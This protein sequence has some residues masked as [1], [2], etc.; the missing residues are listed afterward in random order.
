MSDEISSNND[1]AHSRD[2]DAHGQAAL[3][4][5]E[6]LIHGLIENQVLSV[7]D[8]IEIVDVA[9]EVKI[10]TDT[11]RGDAPATV[12]TTIKLLQDISASLRFDVGGPAQR[13]TPI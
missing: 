12:Q 11:V 7:V 2:A 13:L 3:L 8:V 10:E 6:S 4:L 9:T 1:I 5:V